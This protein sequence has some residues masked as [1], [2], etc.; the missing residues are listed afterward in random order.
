MAW[1]KKILGAL[2]AVVGAYYCAV[3]VLTL[4]RVSDVTTQW[5]RQSGDPDFKYDYGTFLALSAFGAV[6]IAVLG[7]FTVVKGVATARG[8]Q[9]SW[10]GPAIAALPLHGVWFLYRSIGAGLLSRHDQIVV[11][12]DT[13]IQF[14]AVCIGYVALWLITRRPNRRDPAAAAVV[15]AA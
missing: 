11:Q 13:A 4:T 5:V 14:G 12:R 9:A 8:R 15:A 6:S 1:I 3:G 10:L 7:S 2:F